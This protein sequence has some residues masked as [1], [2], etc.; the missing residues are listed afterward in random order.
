[1]KPRDAHKMLV[2]AL[3]SRVGP[4]AAEVPAALTNIVA[5]D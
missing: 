4:S 3:V 1:M 5:A 2:R